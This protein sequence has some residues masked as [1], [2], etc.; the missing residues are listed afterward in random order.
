MQLCFLG[1][2]SAIKNH[3]NSNIHNFQPGVGITSL[4]KRHLWKKGPGDNSLV[5]L[6]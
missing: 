3:R 6:P 2:T 4:K 5:R 1:M